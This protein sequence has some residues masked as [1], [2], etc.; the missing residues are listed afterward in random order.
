MSHGGG[1]RAASENPVNLMEGAELT[2]PT[3]D[4]DAHEE[5]I[6]AKMKTEAGELKFKIDLTFLRSPNKVG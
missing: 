1:A 6:Q 3:E 5:P 4:E 2:E